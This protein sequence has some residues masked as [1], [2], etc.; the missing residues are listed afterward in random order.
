[1]TTVQQVVSHRWKVPAR[2]FTVRTE[3]G[4]R[5]EGTQLGPA[6]P[7]R[8]A[9]VMTH[10]L[11]GWHR[12]PRFARFAERMCR[13]FAVYAFD[14]R[15][16]GR[17]AGVCDFGRAEI[18][19][20][21]AVL[22]R[23]RDAGHARVATMGNSM[24]G[25]AVLRHAGLLGGED[26]VVG[27]SSLAYWDWHGGANPVALRNLRAMIASTPGRTAM[28][29]WGVR[30]PKAW[31][32]DVAMPEAPEDVIGKVAPS[33]VVIVHGADDHLFSEDHAHRLFEAANEPKRLLM[34][35]RFGHAEDG[36]TPAF[37]TRL[38]AVIQGELGAA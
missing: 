17:S 22:R 28:R 24:G 8:P 4:V 5:I 25:I 32:G 30:L 9:L 15:G 1:M 29:P 18:Q 10:G 11:M 12:K 6:D 35:D 16:H 23:A 34:G 33:A 26:V 36:L 19:D 20:V 7:H 3:D 31:P 14:L 27:I 2:P 21:D 38:T 13:A 37:S